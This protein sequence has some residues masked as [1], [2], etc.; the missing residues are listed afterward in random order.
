MTGAKITKSWLDMTDDELKAAIGK[1]VA[2]SSSENEIR[3]RMREMHG[4][5]SYIGVR[6]SQPNVQGKIC[7]RVTFTNRHGQAVKLDF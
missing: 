6:R 7:T 2:E 3:D 5:A 4:F 1:I